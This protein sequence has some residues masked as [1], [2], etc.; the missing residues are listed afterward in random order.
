MVFVGSLIVG[1]GNYLF[2]IIMGRMLGPEDFGLLAALLSITLILAVPT[3]TINH[4]VSKTVADLTG[5]NQKNKIFSFLKQIIKKASFYGVFLSIVFLLFSSQVKKLLNL[6][7][8]AP[9]IVLSGYFLF[10]FLVPVGLGFM[11]GLQQFVRLSFSQIVMVFS[12]L[13]IGVFL[14]KIGLGILGAMIAIPLASVIFIIMVYAWFSR[15]DVLKNE[16]TNIDWKS[17]FSYMKPV[18]IVS[19][20]LVFIY[21][22]DVLF[23]KHFLDQKNAGLY[24]GLVLFGKIIFFAT[25][26]VP[27]VL[28]PIAAKNKIM[29]ISN[30]KVFKIALLVVSFVSG[31]ITLVYFLFPDRIINL[32][33]GAE[34]ISIQPL[35]WKIAVVFT[36]YSIINLISLFALSIRKTNFT[37]VL[38]G[39][40][41]LEVLLLLNFHDNISQILNVYLISVVF[42]LLLLILHF[43]IT[44][45]NICQMKIR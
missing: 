2:Q 42:S 13:L 26:S 12:K 10:S 19:L 32:I 22:I 24:A 6:D 16:E 14:V 7:S 4:V 39:S 27:V 8:I 30:L 21:N 43:F 18:F 36:V 38:V 11:R 23:A 37:Y 1:F 5:K 45:K 29:R 15:R 20:C 40:V 17:L 3:Q 28:F 44:N 41:V 35:L 25:S 31:V 9:L 34:Y 33:L